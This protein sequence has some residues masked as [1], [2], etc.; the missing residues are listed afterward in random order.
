MSELSYIE[1]IRAIALDTQVVGREF[2]A[3]DTIDS[4]NTHALDH[5]REGMVIV[6]DSQTL[7]RGRLGRS[8]HSAPGLGLWFTAVLDAQTEGLTFAAALAVRD[9]LKDR[10]AP[11]IKWPNDVLIG[12]K[13]VCGIL[14]ERRGEVTAVGIGLNVHHRLA[15]FPPELHPTAGSLVTEAG[16]NWSRVELLRGILTHLDGSVMLLRSGKLEEIR[17]AWAEAC[18]IIGRPIRW[19]TNEGVVRDI[20]AA[21]ALVVET[22]S[23]SERVISGEITLG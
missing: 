17:A 9:A 2:I 7:G 4:T 5:G 15:D 20:D 16:G 1:A 12:G 3:F 22:P 21:G 23:G 19:E 11:A 8:W 13:K 6:A 18:A 14:T 10:C